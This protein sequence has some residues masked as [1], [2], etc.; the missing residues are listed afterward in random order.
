MDTCI[1]GLSRQVE[2]G[3]GQQ[4]AKTTSAERSS[5]IQ[6]LHF[7][8]VRIV[9]T[10]QWLQRATIGKQAIHARG[11]QRTTRPGIVAG[12]LQQFAVKVLEIQ[13]D[14]KARGVLAQ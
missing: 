11:Q 8:G 12:E 3:L 5:H 2:D 14:C 7:A 1:P 6:A 9:R 4:A 13:V 10:V